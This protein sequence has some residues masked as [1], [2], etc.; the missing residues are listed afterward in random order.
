LVKVSPRR[1][2]AGIYELRQEG[3]RIDAH[4]GKKTKL[5][6]FRLL[7]HKPGKRRYANVR[8]YLPRFSVVALSDGILTN[9]V[10]DAAAEALES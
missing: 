8:L 7:S 10:K 6:W 1:Y 3:W 4:R 2:G 9:A 5:Y